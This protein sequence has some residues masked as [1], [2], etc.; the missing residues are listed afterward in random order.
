MSCQNR[1]YNLHFKSNIWEAGEP[2]IVKYEH[3]KPSPWSFPLT[4]SK[5]PDLHFLK[6]F[7]DLCIWMIIKSSSQQSQFDI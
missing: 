4:L 2:M 7:Q 3:F 1:Y 6:A 5:E